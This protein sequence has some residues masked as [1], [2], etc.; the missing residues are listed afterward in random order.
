MDELL[1]NEQLQLLKKALHRPGF[2]FIIIGYNHKA[3]Y[4]NILKWLNSTFPDQKQFEL[5]I[6]GNDYR[7]MMKSLNNVGKAW[8]MI[9]D[10][11]RLFTPENEETCTAFN[12]RRD[13]FARNKMVFLCFI[14]E[15]NLKSIPVKIPDLWS[16]RSLELSFRA[17]VV[18]KKLD[19][20]FES[21]SM[22]DISTL[23]GTTIAEKQQE[24]NNLKKQIDAA[25]P[26]NLV[27]LQ[28]LFMQL[29]TI[30][31][32]ISDLDNALEYARKTHKIS[33]QIS[34]RKVEGVSLNMIG[35]I[36]FIWGD[37]KKALN[38]FEQ[39]L[40]IT[41]EINDKAGE[42]TTLNNIS[43]IFKTRGDYQKAMEY[44]E[45]S[46][47]IQREVGD[48]P[49]MAYILINLGTTCLDEKVN[50]PEKGMEYLMECA[51]INK[52]IQNPEIA[53]ALKKWGLPLV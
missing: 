51:E 29:S 27:L 5:Q 23:G 15:E 21:S 46:L 50:Q 41:R 4:N 40:A 32:A 26:E 30:F 44:L 24:I 14:F 9:P 10:F 17:E 6:A 8:V 11:D 33:C 12:Q 1:N 39:A 7:Q 49:G 48:Y 35:Q 3:V 20:L 47:A 38:N 22:V 36:F 19:S 52:K 37:Y 43:Q 18:P 16:L 25:E 34:D 28:A 42:A 45:Q 13:Y 53:E 31:Y 2:R